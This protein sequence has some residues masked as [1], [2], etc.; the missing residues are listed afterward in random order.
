MLSAT[1]DHPSPNHT[2]NISRKRKSS[3][4]LTKRS[5]GN[6]SSAGR[7]G[8]EESKSHA[9]V[10]MVGQGV[11]LLSKHLKKPISGVDGSRSLNWGSQSL[12]WGLRVWVLR[13]RNGVVCVLVQCTQGL[14][15]QND[16]LH[17]KQFSPGMNSWLRVLG[18]GG[19]VCLGCHFYGASMCFCGSN[20]A[21]SSPWSLGRNCASQSPA[22]RRGSSQEIN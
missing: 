1:W 17:L 16:A 4:C 20:K 9:V 13:S 11:L 22:S 12:G 18:L 8:S 3:I 19:F 15:S 10:V 21:G 6:A 5:L 2:K 14:S 7:W